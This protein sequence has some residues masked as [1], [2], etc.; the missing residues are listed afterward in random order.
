[1]KYNA[2]VPNGWVEV[3]VGGFVHGAAMVNWHNNNEEWH[4]VTLHNHRIGVGESYRLVVPAPPA[5]KKEW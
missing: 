1:M 3:A 2:E 4:P 5:K